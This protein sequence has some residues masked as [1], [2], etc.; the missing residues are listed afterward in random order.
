MGE[1]GLSESVTTIRSQ[2]TKTERWFRSF[3]LLLLDAVL[4][5]AAIEISILLRFETDFRTSGAPGD[6]FAYLPIYEAVFLPT[7]LFGGL[8]RIY[9]KYAGLREVVL[10]F[11]LCTVSSGIVYILNDIFTFGFSRAVVAMAAVC[12]ALAI[13]ASRIFGRG[14]RFLHRTALHIKNRDHYK[15]VMIIGA[16]SGGSNVLA[17]YKKKMYENIIP[18]LIV[19]DDPAKRSYR[20]DNVPILGGRKD[21]PGLAQKYNIQEIVISINPAHIADMDEL[22][23][24]CRQTAC[25]I[26]ILA[27]IDNID[28]QNQVTKTWIKDLDIAD[29]LMR[30][31]EHLDLSSVSAY[32]KDKTVL[33]TGGGG[34]IGSELCRQVMRFAPKQLVIF[35]IYENN[36]YELECE[37]K[38]NFNGACREEVVIGS[39]RDIRRLQEV[40]TKYRP[41]VVFHAAAH[42]HVPLMETSYGEAIKNN[43]FGTRNLLEVSAA[44]GVERF[45][46]LSTDK[47]VNPTNIMGATKRINEMLV[48]IFA[49]TSSMKCMMVR[50]GN[51]LGSHGSVIP[52]FEMQIKKGGPVTVTHPDIVRYFMTIPEAAQ[53]VL[54][55]GAFAQNGALYALDMGEPIRI[56]DLAKKVI[57]FHGY[58]P[59]VDMPIKI[60]GLRPGEKLYEELISE[61]EFQRLIATEN[62]KIF[63]VPTTDID[64]KWFY[65]HLAAL[66]REVIG[67]RFEGDDRKAAIQA[68]IK[69]IV[70]CYT[71]NGNGKKQAPKQA[72]TQGLD[73]D[74]SEVQRQSRDAGLSATPP[75]QAEGDL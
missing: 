35:D 10:V 69:E 70:P 41:D 33:I 58:E 66:E 60:T 13:V 75:Y 45:V 28:K 50:F 1:M 57:R 65:E 32:L 27:G 4:V 29:F 16:G 15:R 61:K 43:I 56:M 49:K 39:I 47:A 38:Q 34:S 44:N 67:G 40:F 73:L 18:V 23:H 7:L 22:I 8:Y 2:S 54:Q 11:I 62:E 74:F 20:L 6:F 19:D 52:L 3:G 64:E 55:A 59:D 42:K 26:R 24:F 9:W 36:A 30:N 72:Q 37:L 25:R 48:Q 12:T 63:V 53:L 21:I 46:M 31:E 17:L 71:P 5:A 68:M 14:M 51:V